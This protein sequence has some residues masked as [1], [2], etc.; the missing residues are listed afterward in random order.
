MKLNSKYFNNLKLN[1][2]KVPLKENVNMVAATKMVNFLLRLK[3]RM[4]IIALII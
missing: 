3:H 2:K 1:L 4:N